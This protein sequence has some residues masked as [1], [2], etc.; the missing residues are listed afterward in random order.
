VY[1]K[2]VDALIGGNWKESLELLAEIPAEDKTK[3]FLTDFASA[4][5]N[6]PP[7]DWAGVIHMTSK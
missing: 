5:N 2:A 4:N 7:H 3:E 6:D 1:D